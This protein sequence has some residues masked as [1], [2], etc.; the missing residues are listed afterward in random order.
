MYHSLAWS[1]DD[2][3]PGEAHSSPFT[4]LEYNCSSLVVALLARIGAKEYSVLGV[5]VLCTRS[6]I[7]NGRVG[8]LF[9][10]LYRELL[11]ND[12]PILLCVESRMDV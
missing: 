1:F 2:T 8:G 5:H 11:V 10:Q 7:Q 4:V 6:T 12:V 3:A 9:P